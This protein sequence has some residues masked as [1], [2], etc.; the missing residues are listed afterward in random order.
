[1][2]SINGNACL[3]YL[4]DIQSGAGPSLRAF[5]IFVVSGM[6]LDIHDMLA[7]WMHGCCIDVAS[8]PRTDSRNHAR[9]LKKL[10]VPAGICANRACCSQVSHVVNYVDFT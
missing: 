4:R 5:S 6:Q 9:A 10:S 2:K 1:M 8:S 7:L 3:Y